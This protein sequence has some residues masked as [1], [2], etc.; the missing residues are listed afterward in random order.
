MII[1]DI[2]VL[3]VCVDIEMVFGN[4]VLNGVGVRVSVG[5]MRVV[6]CFLV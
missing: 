2:I 1:F 3:N 4:V 5:V 6:V